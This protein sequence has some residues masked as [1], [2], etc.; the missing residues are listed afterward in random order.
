H[1]GARPQLLD[2]NPEGVRQLLQHVHPLNRLY[3]TLDLRHPARGLPHER[4]QLLLRQLPLFAE[5]GDVTAERAI[6]R[7]DLLHVAS[8]T[9]GLLPSSSF[10]KA[11][12]V[13]A[14]YC[15]RSLS[16]FLV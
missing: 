16:I 5:L 10:R 6:L 2:G 14:R 9:A 15:A 3:A 4:S 12:S 13:L 8:G 7:F 1:R 11:T